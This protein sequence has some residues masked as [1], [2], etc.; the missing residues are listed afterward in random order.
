MERDWAS[1]LTD[2]DRVALLIDSRCDGGGRVA[3]SRWESG[4][5]RL[6]L[7]SPSKY[8]DRGLRPALPRASVGAGLGHSAGAAARFGRPGLLRREAPWQVK[9]ESTRW[10]RKLVPPQ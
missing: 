4:E 2:T 3:G 6:G 8:V 10:R 9:E 5:E 7:C 1:T